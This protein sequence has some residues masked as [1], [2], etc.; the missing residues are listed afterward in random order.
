[1]FFHLSDQLNKR[2]RSWRYCPFVGAGVSVSH[3]GDFGDIGPFL[4]NSVNS[5]SIVDGPSVGFALAGGLQ[6]RAGPLHI[7]PE[8]R[9]TH[10]GSNQ[11]SNAFNNVIR[12]ND[13]EGQVLIGLTF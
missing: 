5:N 9:Y 1:L 2:R 12:T 4:T 6:F 11:I 7:S 3:L 8:I 13:N 10:W